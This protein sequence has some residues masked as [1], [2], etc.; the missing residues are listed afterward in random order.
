MSRFIESICCIDGETLNLDLHQKRVDRVFKC[1]YHQP[2]IQLRET[3]KS[4]P[5]IGKHK[6]RIVYDSSN[7]EMEFQP[8]PQRQIK[9]LKVIDGSHLDYSF[10]YENRSELTSLFEQRGENDDIIIVKNG[11]FTDSYFANLAFF[12]GMNWFTPYNPLLNG[13]K[14]Q[15]LLHQDKISEA[16]ISLDS[17]KEFKL[18]S[19]INAMLDLEEVVVK[20][21]NI[22]SQ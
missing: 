14:R 4:I 21:D 20:V 13:T 6:C 16:S 9:S 19:L 17:L 12:D 2:P 5:R 1:F 3:I 8:Y 7:I 11:M 15:L 18:V 10:K 22:L